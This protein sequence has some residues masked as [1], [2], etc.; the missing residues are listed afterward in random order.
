[1]GVLLG[2]TVLFGDFV[3]QAG[4]GDLTNQLIVVSNSFDF[5]LGFHFIHGIDRNQVFSN[6]S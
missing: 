2:R 4:L 3:V 5:T 1:M 6:F